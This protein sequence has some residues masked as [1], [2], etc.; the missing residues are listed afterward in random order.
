MS[1]ELWNNYKSEEKL[2]FIKL[3]NDFLKEN[4]VI[5]QS[6]I[7]Y[8][9]FVKINSFTQNLEKEIDS[10]FKFLEIMPCNSM[11]EKTNLC[12]YF[13][14]GKILGED[15]LENTIEDMLAKMNRGICITQ[16]E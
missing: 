5:E 13:S 15:D 1:L 16:H 10:D 3:G 9:D 14:K 6:Q 8:E 12:H 7:K 4:D 2:D 11:D